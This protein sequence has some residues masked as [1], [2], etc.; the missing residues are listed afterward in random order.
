MSSF[1]LHAQRATRFMHGTG[2]LSVI[3]KVAAVRLSYVGLRGS[4][5]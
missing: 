4:S 5:S 1:P 2:I 3:R